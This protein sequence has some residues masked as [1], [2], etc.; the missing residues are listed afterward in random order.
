M[1][2]FEPFPPDTAATADKPARP[3]VAITQDA[4]DLLEAI[5][6]AE[7]AQAVPYLRMW[8]VDPASGEPVHKDENNNP[9]A[10]L[11]LLFAEPPRFGQSFGDASTRF[12]ERPGVSLERITITTDAPMGVITYRHV[13]MSFVV[14]RPDVIFER[15]ND[16]RDAWSSLILPG[17]VHALSYGWKASLGVKNG[18]LNGEGLDDS[19]VKPRLI[20]P[21]ISSIRFVV[22]N[23][24]F[25]ISPDGQF[26][27]NVTALED[28]EYNLRRVT[29]GN[30]P[31]P[32]G[33]DPD[34][35]TIQK[36]VPIG[37]YDARG[38]SAVK[39]LQNRVNDLTKDGGFVKFDDLCNKLFVPE[40]ER[41]FKEIGYHDPNMILGD[42]NTKVGHPAERFKL[43]T[44]GGGSEDAWIGDFEIPVKDIRD[45][46]GTFFK[47]GKPMTL[48]NFITPFLRI[49]SAHNTWDRKAAS[50]D[51]KG[52][53][54]N[55]VPT[56]FMRTILNPSTG[57]CGMYIFDARREFTKFSES[58]YEKGNKK[59]STRE[60][61]KK[62]MRDKGIPFVSFLRGN[63][64]IKDSNFSV[65]Q[66]EQIK[67]IL[68]RR[69][70]SDPTKNEITGKPGIALK[71]DGK[72]SRAPDVE[73]L[74]YSSAISGD[75]T[76]I[77]NFAFDLFGMLWIDFGVPVWSGPFLV[78]K[79]T[80]VIER[81]DFTT[82]I[83][84]QSE[85]SDPLGTQ[86]RHQAVLAKSEQQK[87]DDANNKNKKPG[88]KKPAGR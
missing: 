60:D 25:R 75:I 71:S 37:P 31:K 80:D 50:R 19:S 23:Y 8:Q 28:G 3:F 29:V 65:V 5:T 2:K 77:G 61:I 43:K 64:Y 46:F 63:S 15:T 76:M 13:D 88:K 38:V 56:M 86:G 14:H 66:D 44:K 33:P 85:G 73:E 48:Y 74:L 40:I 42:F 41:A 47:N 82:T 26:T 34:P 11:S 39:E 12:L 84:I 45:L 24:D 79:R 59:N 7:K 20:V 16:E 70:F 55:I 18:L 6:P 52:K 62:T 17:A 30:P 78:K 54:K 58:D 83:S 27:F 36:D 35:N 21:A 67:G 49:L 81:G 51:D 68:I 4:V 1:G 69:A 32:F 72:N 53:A 87:Q 10:P 9:K 57:A 22:T